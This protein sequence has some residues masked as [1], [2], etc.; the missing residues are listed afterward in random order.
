MR[1]QPQ[2]AKHTRIS[3]A[4]LDTARQALSEAGSPTE[5]TTLV[6]IVLK[7]R[8][9]RKSPELL[10]QELYK[11]AKTGERGFVVEE[12]PSFKRKRLGPR[13]Q[14]PNRGYLA[15]AMSV[16]SSP[17]VPRGYVDVREIA[18]LACEAGILQTVSPVPEYWMCLMM[19][20]RPDVFARS[21]LLTIG[22]IDWRQTAAVSGA[23]TK[24]TEAARRP[25]SIAEAI[26]ERDLE[27]L[28]AER[29]ELLER[30]LQLLGRQYSTPVGRLDLLCK[31][32][33]GAFVV[34]ELKSFGARTDEII[35]Q[36]TRYMG[37]VKTHLAKP[38][39]LV[40][41]IIVVG[42]VDD[43]LNYAVVAIPNLEIRTFD[44]TISPAPP[45]AGSES[46]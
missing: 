14:L 45:F 25:S 27:S 7:T 44:V 4:F 5:V 37:Y 31:D 26:Y 21:G 29:L 2:P 10:G 38:G 3:G 1:L 40:R 23:A 30:G 12:Y 17:N 22:L 9:L 32:R 13:T 46:G 8:P 42:R 15:A 35:D 19:G 34:V 39:Q 33:R 24:K 18:R 20:Q 6:D 28:V 11:T 43:S 36:I 41:G 16:L